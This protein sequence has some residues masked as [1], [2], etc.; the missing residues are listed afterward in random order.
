MNTAIVH[1]I[2]NFTQTE[3]TLVQQLLDATYLVLDDVFFQRNA[4]LSG[5]EAR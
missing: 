2:G 5:K 1:H 4:L 3:L